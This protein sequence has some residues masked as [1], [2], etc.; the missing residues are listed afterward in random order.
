MGD[1]FRAQVPGGTMDLT[2]CEAVG[3]PPRPHGRQPFSLLFRSPDGTSVPQ[4]GY[5]V[6]HPGLGEFDLFVVPLGPDAGGMR[7]EAVFG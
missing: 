3:L 7:Y 6:E 5:P 4:A 2:L 1:T